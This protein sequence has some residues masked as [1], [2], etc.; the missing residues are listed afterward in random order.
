[1]GCG[2]IVYDHERHAYG[3]DCSKLGGRSSF[4]G[5]LKT[6][7]TEALETAAPTIMALGT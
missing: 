3:G 7:P 5:R 4:S 2:T 6:A 1:M